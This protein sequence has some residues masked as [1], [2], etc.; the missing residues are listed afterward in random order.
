MRRCDRHLSQEIEPYR[1]F[2]FEKSLRKY[3]AYPYKKI[4]KDTDSLSKIIHT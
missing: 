4:K 3:K 2:N 1:E